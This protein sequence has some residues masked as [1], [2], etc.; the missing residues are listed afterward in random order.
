MTDNQDYV[1]CVKLSDDE[2]K[3]TGRDEDVEMC[4]KILGL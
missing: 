1:N 4:I 3:H 2:G